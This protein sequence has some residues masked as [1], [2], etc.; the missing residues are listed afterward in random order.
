MGEKVLIGCSHVLWFK[1]LEDSAY[2]DNHW[3][4]KEFSGVA[5]MPIFHEK[6][7]DMVETANKN[8]DTVFL[9]PFR[10]IAYNRISDWMEESLKLDDAAFYANRM[11]DKL[12][13]SA[14]DAENKNFINKI[15]IA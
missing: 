3:N 9:F 4:L 2:S 15:A 14:R 6:M 5:S 12:M 7:I 8:N 10:S 13:Q 11:S 1:E